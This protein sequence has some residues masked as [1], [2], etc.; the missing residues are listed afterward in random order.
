[1]NK[2]GARKDGNQAA[3]R[4]RDEKTTQGI[5]KAALELGIELGFDGLTVEGVAA[6]AGVGKS[7]IYRRWPDVW[8]IVA[9]AVFADV[10]RI[11]PVLERATARESFRASMH[12]IARSFRGRHGEILRPLIGRAQ[13]DK[14]LRQAL[15]KHWLSARREISRKI[16][17]RG[18][19]SGELRA[20]LEPDIVLDALYGPLY[21]R[22]LLP[23]DGDVIRLSDAYIDALI[24]TVF[25]GLE[26]K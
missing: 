16:V 21:H 10:G 1:M 9:D 6:R 14:T 26:R 3:G 19:A 24:D 23:Y 12:L 13:V 17:R 8:S 25:G 15:A 2:S 22:L 5:L 18:I 4:P 7:T 11:A 20:G